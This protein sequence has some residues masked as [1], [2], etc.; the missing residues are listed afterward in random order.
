MQ[1]SLHLN[2][3]TFSALRSKSFRIFLAGQAAALTG[4]W[5]QRLANSWLVYR[6]TSSAF[7]LG[8]IELCAN[9]PIFFV[10]LLAGAWLDK[11]DIRKTMIATQTLIM[12]HAAI[13]AFLV[14][15][16][17]V[18]FWHVFL[19]SFYLGLVNAVDLP[20]RQSSIM[21]MV[22]DKFQLKSALALHSVVFN[23]SR[24]IG[25]SI[26]GLLIG[27]MGEGFCFALTAV[28]YLPVI[29][30]LTVIRFR[31]R[32]IS[33]EK[34]NKFAEIIEGIKYVGK[35]FYLRI[36]LTFLCIFATFSYSYMVLF[37]IFAKDILIGGSKLLGFFLGGIG[38]G[39]IFGAFS[40]ASFIKVQRLPRII[41]VASLLHVIFIALFAVSPS[42]IL[43]LLLT[44]PVG[45]GLVVPFVAS[46]TL[47]QIL[48]DE[49]KRSRVISLYT[50][51]VV[52]VGPI[53]AFVA[54]IFAEAIGARNTMLIFAFIM[55]MANIFLW[56]RMDHLEKT[57]AGI[58]KNV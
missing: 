20:A 43:S 22:E 38:F 21:L 14:L 44:I 4:L 45:F 28:C 16:G 32:K 15:S 19:L 46:N 39:A 1:F 42:K 49:D 13:M 35:T 12:L 50:I 29:F 31:D 3:D 48:A 56:S 11:H 51:C 37:P 30:A 55:L 40:L 6:V 54:G 10:G 23:L 33:K 9:V 24:L 41:A 18:V 17:V 2:P 58:L 7:K 53:G 57:V 34:K 26:A 36:I 8:S 27:V 47:L 25:P 52:G 5:M